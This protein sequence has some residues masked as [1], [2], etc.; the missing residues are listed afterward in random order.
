MA[1]SCSPSGDLVAE[2]TA[3][4]RSAA[5]WLNLSALPRRCFLRA[6]APYLQCRVFACRAPVALPISAGP[7][8]P[9]IFPTSR[10]E[11]EAPCLE[12]NWERRP[13]ACSRFSLC[14]TV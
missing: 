7:G 14:V 9:L 1:W 10:R 4:S 6:D 8:L 3:A 2:A 12:K 5:Y 11:A 13:C